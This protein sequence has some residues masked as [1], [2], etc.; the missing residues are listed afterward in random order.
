MA[1]IVVIMLCAGCGG[2]T[3]NSSQK[4]RKP[5]SEFTLES[6]MDSKEIAAVQDKIKSIRFVPSVYSTGASYA[7]YPVESSELYEIGIKGIPV[8]IDFA[9]NFCVETFPDEWS[10]YYPLFYSFGALALLRCDE[11]YLFFVYGTD[12]P[13]VILKNHILSAENKCQETINS[14]FESIEFK[15]A[16]LK[17]Y[18]L[19]AIP[20]VVTEIQNGNAEYEPF[21]TAIGL[22]LT[23]EEF[24][25]YLTEQTDSVDEVY[26][27]IRNDRKAADFDY[28]QW[29]R[30]N[31]DDLNAMFKYLEAYAAE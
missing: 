17:N 10:D 12:N 18:G 1:F 9:E 19:L 13:L 28:K 31:E 6:I 8:L 7:G 23:T 20:Y 2:N 4:E 30:E 29:L 16:Q 11:N 26:N 22:H 25:M 27:N 15:I 14:S 3:Q 5:Q 21:F 24:M